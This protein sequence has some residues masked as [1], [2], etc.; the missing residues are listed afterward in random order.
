MNRR[1]SDG[2]DRWPCVKS[3]DGLAWLCR[4]CHKPLGGRKTAWCSPECEYEV[5]ARCD[6]GAA[7]GLV[8]ARD[9]GVCA[10]CGVDT[11][12]LRAAVDFYAKLYL[13]VQNREFEAGRKWAECASRHWPQVPAFVKAIG[14]VAHSWPETLWECNH[15]IPLAEGGSLCDLDNLETLCSACHA[16]HT[17]QLMG[18][19]AKGKRRERKFARSSS[20]S[21]A[22]EIIYDEVTE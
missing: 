22:K 5:K 7:R 16:R 19:L 17:A 3:L 2:W 9:N 6:F 15:I 13:R 14:K 8:F 4:W 12:A 1:S 21:L 10:H 11:E 18:R 20:Q